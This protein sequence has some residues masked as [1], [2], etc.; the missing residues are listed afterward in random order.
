MEYF[1]SYRS[2]TQVLRFSIL[3]YGTPSVACYDI[4]KLFNLL[5]LEDIAVCAVEPATSI[6]QC[7]SISVH[8]LCKRECQHFEDPLRKKATCNLRY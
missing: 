7:G 6:M 2:N 5:K 1:C 3:R 4:Q 8:N